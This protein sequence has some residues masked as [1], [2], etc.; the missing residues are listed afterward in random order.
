MSAWNNALSP[1]PPPSLE[2][3]VSL[4]EGLITGVAGILDVLAG[5]LEAISFLVNLGADPL[6]SILN[7]VV[8][9]LTEI[10]D[11][12][13]NIGFSV[14]L[15]APPTWDEEGMR[16]YKG[17]IQDLAASVDDAGDPNRPEFTEENSYFGIA[18]LA[19]ANNIYERQR[20]GLNAFEKFYKGSFPLFEQSTPRIVPQAPG[21]GIV[22]PAPPEKKDGPTEFPRVLITSKEENGSA[23]VTIS[24]GRLAFGSKGAFPIP[25]VTVP[26]T[27]LTPSSGQILLAYHYTKAEFEAKR[28][29]MPSGEFPMVVG[30][31]SEYYIVF[32][33]VRVSDVTYSPDGVRQ[34]SENIFSAIPFAA[35][36]VFLAFAETDPSNKAVVLDTDFNV[37]IPS[38]AVKLARKRETVN[39]TGLNW[40]G[41]P[42]NNWK[43]RNL[44]LYNEGVTYA[45]QLL[46]KVPAP[47]SISNSFTTLAALLRKIADDLRTLADNLKRLSQDI[48]DISLL[49]GNVSFMLLTP[50]PAAYSGPEPFNLVNG[51]SF[52]LTPGQLA[53][54]NS[55]GAVIPGEKVYTINATAAELVSQPSA[56][57]TLDNDTGFKAQIYK[58]TVSLD[59]SSTFISSGQFPSSSLSKLGTL[60][61]VPFDSLLTS[62]GTPKLTFNTFGKGVELLTGSTMLSF[63]AMNL[64][65]NDFSL[66]SSVAAD[67]VYSP[68]D[69]TAFLNVWSNKL[70][71]N[72]GVADLLS[73]LGIPN[74]DF[75]EGK[76]Q[77]TDSRQFYIPQTSSMVITTKT[78]A[79]EYQT[80]NLKDVLGLGNVT[81]SRLS[82]TTGD[83]RVFRFNQNSGFKVT[84]S[85]RSIELLGGGARSTLGLLNPTVTPTSITS[86]NSFLFNVPSTWYSITAKT[87]LVKN[88]QGSLAAKLGWSN[89]SNQNVLVEGSP[90]RLF[91]WQTGLAFKLILKSGAA[92]LVSANVNLVT[93]ATNLPGEALANQITYALRQNPQSSGLEECSYASGKFTLSFYGHDNPTTVNL[94]GNEA[95]LNQIGFEEDEVSLSNK[96]VTGAETVSYVVN[97]DTLT[98]MIGQE[99]YSV[100]IPNGVYTGDALAN[101][102]EDALQDQTNGTEQV[103]FNTN[104]GTFTLV[105]DVDGYSWIN[106]GVV[107]VPALVNA[108]PAQLLASLNAPLSS[109][110]GTL[111]TETFSFGGN[112]FSFQSQG[113]SHC[114]IEGPFLPVILGFNTSGAPANNIFPATLPIRNYYFE[115]SQNTLQFEVSDI[116]LTVT[117]PHSVY[118]S[119]VQVSDYLNSSGFISSAIS[120]GI[121]SISPVVTT[122]VLSNDLIT[123]DINSTY[124]IPSLVAYLQSELNDLGAPEEFVVAVT[125]SGRLSITYPN[126][127]TIVFSEPDIQVSVLDMLG[128]STTPQNINA[129]WISDTLKPYFFGP[130]QSELSLK[131]GSTE[132]T[133]YYFNFVQRYSGEEFSLQLNTELTNSLGSSAPV[134]S[135]NESTG[136]FTVTYPEAGYPQI[137]SQTLSI[138]T[139]S[140]F[141]SGNQ[142]A[143][144]VEQALRGLTNSTGSERVVFNNNKFTFLEPYASAYEIADT[145]GL[146]LYKLMG[147]GTGSA[148]TSDG[149]YTGT[150]AHYFFLNS[151]NNSFTL[152]DGS[153]TFP[154]TLTAST[155]YEKGSDIAARLQ[156]SIRGATGLL[157]AVEYQPST[158]TYSVTPDVV[159]KKVVD[160]YEL[161]YEANTDYLVIEA[162][163]FYLSTKLNMDYPSLGIKLARPEGSPT[164]ALAMPFLTKIQFSTD[165][166]SN[167]KLE[168]LLGFGTTEV[169][170]LREDSLLSS[171]A[172]STEV[173]VNYKHAVGG[174]PKVFFSHA[175]NNTLNIKLGSKTYAVFL[176]P[177]YVLQDGTQYASSLQTLIRAVS[178]RNTS[179]TYDPASQRFVL[180]IDPAGE[181]Y[182]EEHSLSFTPSTLYTPA[183]VLVELNTLSSATGSQGTESF[184]YD[185]STQSFNFV[186]SANMLL[187]LSVLEEVGSIYPYLNVQADSD[188]LIPQTPPSILTMGPIKNFAVYANINDEIEGEFN[189]EDFLEELVPG[190]YSGSSLAT[191]LTDLLEPTGQVDSIT[192]D[193]QTSVFEISSKEG[194]FLYSDYTFNTLPALVDLDTVGTAAWLTTLFQTIPNAEGTD[195]FTPFGAKF[196]F[197]KENLLKLV[198][199]ALYDSAPTPAP[200]PESIL[201]LKTLGI[202]SAKEYL[203]DSEAL[204]FTALM[205]ETA[206]FS[207]TP[208]R[209][210]FSISYDGLPSMDVVLVPEED[211]L[212]GTELASIIQLRVRDYLCSLAVKDLFYYFN[213]ID[214]L[215]PTGVEEVFPLSVLFQQDPQYTHGLVSK[216]AIAKFEDSVIEAYFSQQNQRFTQAI[217]TQFPPPSSEWL[218]IPIIGDF[219]YT[220]AS[221]VTQTPETLNNLWKSTVVN[222][223]KKQLRDSLRLIYRAFVLS[224]PDAL[225]HLDVSANIKSVLLPIVTSILGFDVSTADI[226]DYLASQLA[227]NMSNIITQQYRYAVEVTFDVET[228]TFK[229]KS[230][231]SGSL[232]SVKVTPFGTTPNFSEH[233]GFPIESTAVGSGNVEYAHRVLAREI[234]NIMSVSILVKETGMSVFPNLYTSAGEAVPAAYSYPHRIYLPLEF[235]TP[236]KVYVTYTSFSTGPAATM[237]FATNGSSPMLTKL[238]FPSG[239]LAGK[240]GKAGFLG[241]FTE[242]GP[243]DM[244]DEE[245]SFIMASIF[246]LILYNPAD[247]IKPEYN[248]YA[249]LVGLD[250][251]V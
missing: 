125:E 163:A 40:Y 16:G 144:L 223:Q 246:L 17:F 200:L 84:A 227:N 78:L 103:T 37:R 120:N 4:L 126:L 24:E 248:K 151:T 51:D 226:A 97:N 180:A 39:P 225:N 194:G 121:L 207:I 198:V 19:G 157:E 35:A 43:L 171:L 197:Y 124:T 211:P 33:Y 172:V 235:N 131:L 114:L 166:S 68:E 11:S 117:I 110:T 149:L 100:T 186:D 134:F 236:A 155:D 1:T 201:N 209:N 251:W 31:N 29:E 159:G 231:V 165:N 243:P 74:P 111:G 62:T 25:S 193:A 14:F 76:Y 174:L 221:G 10:I 229:F 182:V 241:A 36:G 122:N 202:I 22:D 66:T 233:I 219:I 2:Q 196:T 178:D 183:Q 87:R 112:S 143:S 160:N 249:K 162:F 80:S 108:S 176:T 81:P 156:T 88:I 52:K 85:K 113:M 212:T 185:S 161:L 140:G 98:F 189:N 90:S 18:L 129:T 238:G 26:S 104:E 105:T 123:F 55:D 72:P 106:T 168:E 133:L 203:S 215:V 247:R 56:R 136:S 204:T 94:F 101:L 141:L 21:Y 154:I 50:W 71:F 164:L 158:G 75:A 102:I 27:Y 42:E 192:W 139:Q 61:T 234:S 245:M 89:V 169:V 99:S 132:Y 216:K 45:E 96:S 206:P 214:N 137:N 237:L 167:L 63:L 116:P 130:T 148:V 109:I 218:G 69:S 190:F 217:N 83:T 64:G 59:P 23:Q 107:V 242:A 175:S 41:G 49:L 95:F 181:R 115:P 146:S 170:A 57:F 65:Y 38:R 232:S 147:F 230:P 222:F 77:G 145:T 3:G 195:L 13:G 46:S 191:H 210:T 135:Y 34:T 119:S 92:T 9:F 73:Y 118:L 60:Q 177:T 15:Y 224:V 205:D 79:R 30:P 138:P 239:E 44:P 220:I 82:D 6:E 86:T 184:S 93:T 213:Y 240:K 70:V 91:S 8:D 7:T 12:L 179:L 250:P 244:I 32:G 53:A 20:Q 54:D 150:E 152:V 228:S 48:Q 208:T 127:N 47:E 128:M 28:L 153:G 173:S 67:R 199:T 58:R 5:V 142:V 187:S 188:L